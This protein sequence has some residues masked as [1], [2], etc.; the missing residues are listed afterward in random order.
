MNT[1]AK[2]ILFVI[3]LLLV[4]GISLVPFHVK[5]R[6]GTMGA[7]HNAG[8]VLAFI[9]ATVLACWLVNS[10][11]ARVFCCLGV[12]V[13]AL[14]LEKLEQLS[15]HLPYEWHDIRVD[16][17]GILIGFLLTLLSRSASQTSSLDHTA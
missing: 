12:L 7:W 4:T 16:S 13:I 15:S 1:K 2:L 17:I 9:A 8:H 3:W 11:P 5:L 6:L 14:T 10:L